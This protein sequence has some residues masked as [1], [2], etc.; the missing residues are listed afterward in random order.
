MVTSLKPVAAGSRVLPSIQPAT[1]ASDITVTASLGRLIS[2]TLNQV[3][4][5]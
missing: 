2:G 3:D 1:T 4:F 5:P